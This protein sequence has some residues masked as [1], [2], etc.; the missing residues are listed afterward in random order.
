MME[1]YLKIYWQIM[2]KSW[3]FV[4]PQKWE[5]YLREARLSPFIN[6]SVFFSKEANHKK[7]N[8]QNL[9]HVYK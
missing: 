4:S 1:K 8:I 2:E 3:N 7:G 6:T 5:P 9:Q